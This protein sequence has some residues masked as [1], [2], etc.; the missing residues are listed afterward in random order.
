[1]S[2]EA[3]RGRLRVLAVA[4]G[5][6]GAGILT[7]L[8]LTLALAGVLAVANVDLDVL[9]SVVLTLA[10]TAGVAF[11]GVSLA[12]VRLRGLGSSF[13]G[14]RF[15]TV[16]DLAWVGG[17]YVLALLSVVAASAVVAAGG[18]EAA[19]NQLSQVGLEHPEVLLLIVPASLLLIGPGEELLF[20]G[21]V[22]GTLRESFGAVGAVVLAA[23]IFA[24]VHFVAVSGGVGARLTTIA[25]LFLPS[26][27]FGAAYERTGNLVV[28]ALVHGLYNSTLAVLLYVVVRF[29]GAAAPSAA[30]LAG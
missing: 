19:P 10:L 23:A 26:L 5:V 7:A 9:T 13:I 6:A 30:W 22:Q 16:R 21:V 15:P 12:Y 20:R 14:V 28:P 29:G 3:S 25:I 11:G 8:V 1:M 4:V 24:S 2:L 18:G 17:G 27:V